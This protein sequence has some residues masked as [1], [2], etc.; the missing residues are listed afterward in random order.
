MGY[1]KGYIGEKS[2]NIFGKSWGY[3]GPLDILRKT[4]G[5]I[6]QNHGIYSAIIMGNTIGYNCQKLWHIFVKTKGY[7]G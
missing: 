1:I 6:R 3:T 7:I 5:N 2:L 4:K